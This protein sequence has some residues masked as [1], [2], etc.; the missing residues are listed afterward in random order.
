VGSA[1]NTKADGPRLDGSAAKDLKD[2]LIEAINQ[3][4]VNRGG[5]DDE[6]DAKPAKKKASK[7]DDEEEDAKPAKKTAKKK[8]GKG[9]DEEEDAKPAKKKASK[10]DDEEDA[11]PAKKTAKK[12]P[13]KGDDEEADAKPAK[14][15]P[16]KGGDDE[17]DAKPAKKSA[18]SKG[19]DMKGGDKVKKGDDEEGAALKTKKSSDTEEDNP[20]PKSKK[21]PAKSGDGEEGGDEVATKDKD[22]DK[23]EIEEKDTGS[24]MDG[25]LA[26]SPGN[27]AIDATVGVSFNARRLSWKTSSDLAPSMGSPGVGKPPNY[28]GLPAPGLL[29]DLTAYPL[30]F[31]HKDDSIKKNIGLNIMYDK[32]LAINSKAGTATLKT[33]A[34]RFS[35][36]GVFRYPFNKT[37][38]SPVVGGSLSYGQQKFEIDGADI[39]NVKYSILSPSVFLRYPM[40]DKIV[41]NVNVG[42]MVIS[43]T[44]TLQ[45]TDQYGS[46]SVNG[47]EGEAGGDYA[48]TKAVVL[49]AAL[50]FETIGFTFKGNGAMTTGRDG[51]PEQDVQGARDSYIGGAVTIGYLY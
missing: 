26:L 22:K 30:A 44:G 9:D 31:T 43:N 42:Y 8:P 47:F 2:E 32:V 39:P 45:S 14:K 13:G 37:E 46:A 23:E 50:K 24:K 49:R 35:V 48:I 27:R 29:I 34:S 38:M 40:S 17:E 12:K 51:D 25:A 11:K 16:G 5:G 18:F 36:G 1:I 33:Q 41:L 3:L 6:E 28:N 10:G 4:D 15:K 21:R 20:L 7:G 19:G